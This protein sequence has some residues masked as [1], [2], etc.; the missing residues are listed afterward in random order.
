VRAAIPENTSLRRSVSYGSAFAFMEVA[1][2]DG[3]AGRA[4]ETGNHMR[5]H[6]LPAAEIDGQQRAVRGAEGEQLSAGDG[7][8]GDDQFVERPSGGECEPLFR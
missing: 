2:L 4:R 5:R 6:H 3:D 7:R 8:S 1:T